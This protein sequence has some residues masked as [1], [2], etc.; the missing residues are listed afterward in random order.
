MKGVNRSKSSDGIPD[1]KEGKSH[2][3]G[4]QIGVADDKENQRKHSHFSRFGFGSSRDKMTSNKFKNEHEKGNKLHK[5]YSYQA[6]SSD[7]INN[8]AP[9]QKA[10]S[11]PGASVVKSG[12]SRPQPAKSQGNQSDTNRFIDTKGPDK[13]G[14]NKFIKKNITKTKSLDDNASENSNDKNPAKLPSVQ[15]RSLPGS[16]VRRN[17]LPVR[18]KENVNKATEVVKKSDS[19]EYEAS[20][21]TDTEKVHSSVVN[22]EN[23]KILIKPSY[24]VVNRDNDKVLESRNVPYKSST[25]P[26]D[27]IG[28]NKNDRGQSD[29]CIKP[30]NSGTNRKFNSLNRFGFVKKDKINDIHKG[31]KSKELQKAERCTLKIYRKYDVP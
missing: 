8:R 18:G 25:L 20:D 14:M 28:S 19:V 6:C 16:F 22:Q 1:S 26:I 2:A 7:D 3:H 24:N 31:T 5:S 30:D 21:R 4:D 13:P 27:N 11:L 9:L 17:A 12:K 15:S 10:N 29:T 23:S